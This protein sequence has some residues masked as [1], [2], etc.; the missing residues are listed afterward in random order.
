MAAV[1]GEDERDQKEKNDKSEVAVGERVLKQGNYSLRRPP[2]LT[3]PQ[4]VIGQRLATSVCM[5]HI[6]ALTPS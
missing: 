5:T 3:I 4:A 6:P 2:K 1:K